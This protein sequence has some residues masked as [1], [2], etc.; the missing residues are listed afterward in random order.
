MV[1]NGGRGRG[2]VGLMGRKIFLEVVECIG[3]RMS[4]F[5]GCQW[6][7]QGGTNLH[8]YLF[9]KIKFKDGRRTKIVGGQKVSILTTVDGQKNHGATIA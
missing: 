5:L 6:P 4:K 2:E 8:E 9:S 7:L 3:Q 1:R